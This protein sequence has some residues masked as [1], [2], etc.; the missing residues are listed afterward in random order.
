M[1]VDGI[2]EVVSVIRGAFPP[3]CEP[4]AAEGIGQAIDRPQA[5]CSG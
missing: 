2:S 4:I 5:S 1:V 3:I